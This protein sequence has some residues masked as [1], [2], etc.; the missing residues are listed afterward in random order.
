MTTLGATEAES[1]LGSPTLTANPER[2]L[3]TL[4]VPHGDG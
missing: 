1:G 3:G 4:A 2:S